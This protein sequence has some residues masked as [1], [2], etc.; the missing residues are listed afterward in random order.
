MK[1]RY[2]LFQTNTERTHYRQAST[3]R[4]AKGRFKSWKKSSKYT[5]TISLKHKSQPGT[6]AQACNPS[7]L[8]GRGRRIT[9]SRDRDQPGQHGETLSLLKI[10]KISWTQWR[11]PIISATQE[12]RQENCLNPGGGGCG[13]PRSRHCTPAWVT[14]VK[15]CL[16]NKN[17]NRQSDS[18]QCLFRKWCQSC[19]QGGDGE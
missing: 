15:L 17:K 2:S 4:T 19:L 14:R 8:G 9:R 5:K 13:E 16:K 1:E 7:T 11:V 18:F 10:Q 3:T 12:L 6:V